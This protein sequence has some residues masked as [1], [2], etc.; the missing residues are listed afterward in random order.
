MLNDTPMNV[1][2]DLL[3]GEFSCQRR[4][5]AAILLAD[6]EVKWGRKVR[7]ARG[8][9]VGPGDKRQLT[10]YVSNSLPGSIP[11][12]ALES[13]RISIPALT[14]LVMRSLDARDE[15]ALKSTEA[16]AVVAST[17]TQKYAYAMTCALED[18]DC[19][20]D[21]FDNV[22]D[23]IRELA[24]ESERSRVSAALALYA[25]C[26]FLGDVERAANLTVQYCSAACGVDLL[27][28]WDPEDAAREEDEPVELDVQRIIR[29]SIRGRRHTLEPAGT[30]FGSL[31][32][33]EGD[34][35]ADV[36]NSVSYQHLL[37]YQDE[38]DG[39]WYAVGLGSKHGTTIERDGEVIVV[40]EPEATR[41]DE[42]AQPV[43]IVPGDV[44]V[45]GSTRF[46]V[47]LYQRGA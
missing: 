35:V 9:A 31:P 20:A 17:L 41:P 12:D 46:E 21:I 13:P 1:F 44:I 8:V 42:E 7:N 38:S 11:P 2:F 4:A 43:K 33:T 6:R 24:F 25:L 28:E 16:Y 45:L 32:S 19:A 10:D 23:S 18:Y 29:G 27:A 47:Q 14:D 36:N 22:L 5:A 34:Y 15:G 40:E 30:M 37:V 39:A 3:E 26:A